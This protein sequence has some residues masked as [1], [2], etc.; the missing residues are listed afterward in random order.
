L[1]AWRKVV[2]WTRLDKSE[3]RALARAEAAAIYKSLYWDGCN[4]DALPAGLDLMLFDFAVNSGP[5]KA[6]KTLQ[7]VLKVRADGLVGPLTLAARAA[8]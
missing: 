7:G 8:W 3:V 2:P 1:A 5:V 4:G 6:I